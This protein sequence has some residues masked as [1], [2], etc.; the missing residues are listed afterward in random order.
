MARPN[1]L[2]AV[3]SCIHD[4]ERGDHEVIRGTWGKDAAAAGI[5]VKFFVGLPTD[6]PTRASSRLREDEIELGVKDD[7][8]HLT[9]K[10]QAICQSV[11]GKMVKNLFLCDTDTFVDIP[12][13]LKSAYESYDYYGYFNGSM[14]GTFS[15]DAIDR[16]GNHD[17]HDACYPW[18]S[19]GI[20]YFLSQ[21]AFNIVAYEFM[22]A[23]FTEDLNVGQVLGPRIADGEITVGNSKDNMFSVH[24]PSS[25][26]KHNYDEETGHRW[27]R[28]QWGNK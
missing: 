20:G 13:M 4:K 23:A 19:G 8:S 14:T 22:K 11:S 27:M 12:R 17:K 1:I 28:E 10:T 6:R 21:K 18:A 9:H 3:K 24:F 7:Y 2:I 15:Y 5:P 25:Y 16:E 26:Y